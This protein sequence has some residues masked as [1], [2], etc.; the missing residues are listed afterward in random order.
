MDKCIKV[1]IPTGEILLRWCDDL[2][3][4]LPET[5][6]SDEKANKYTGSQIP[7]INPSDEYDG[8]VEIWS[9]GEYMH[10]KVID[11]YGDEFPV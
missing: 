4:Y 6:Q 11:Q 9:G 1:L 2:A 5:K 7:S 3:T 10:F 8:W